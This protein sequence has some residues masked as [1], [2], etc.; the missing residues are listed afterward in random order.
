MSTQIGDT[1]SYGLLKFL[2]FLEAPLGV[3]VAF[4]NILKYS[5]DLVHNERVK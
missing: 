4:S 3:T 5:Q 1:L 2:Y